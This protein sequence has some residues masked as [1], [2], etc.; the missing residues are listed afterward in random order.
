MASTSPAKKKYSPDLSFFSKN[1]QN[2]VPSSIPLNL[3]PCS[4]MGMFI[5]AT[6]SAISQL[7]QKDTLEALAR[8]KLP[9]PPPFYAQG[10]SEADRVMNGFFNELVSPN[11]PHTH[12]IIDCA[13]NVSPSSAP[14]SLSPPPSPSP[15]NNNNNNNNNNV[16]WYKINSDESDRLLPKPKKHVSSSS[17]SGF[18]SGSSS[19]QFSTNSNSNNNNNVHSQSLSLSLTSTSLS[20]THLLKQSWTHKHTHVLPSHIIYLTVLNPLE[21]FADAANRSNTTKSQSTINSNFT[22]WTEGVSAQVARVKSKNSSAGRGCQLSVVVLEV[23]ADVVSGIS[24]GSASLSQEQQLQVDDWN[25]K[26][27]AKLNN[28]R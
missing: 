28:T 21:M 4:P 18:G 12:S 1:T 9:S 11:S 14:P 8:S 15:P 7:E 22:R 17:G 6:G 2:N 26:L 10:I 5:T 16:T 19:R 3:A 13:S 23:C 25:K 20:P 27:R 24:G